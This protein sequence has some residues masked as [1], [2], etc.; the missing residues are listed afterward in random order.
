MQGYVDLNPVHG[1]LR[2][3]KVSRL[4]SLATVMRG[5]FSVCM[6]WNIIL[7]KSL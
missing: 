5:N 4:L 3:S 6:F 2:F 7:E 1:E